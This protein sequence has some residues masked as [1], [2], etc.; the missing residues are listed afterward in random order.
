MPP[1]KNALQVLQDVFGYPAFRA[2]QQEVIDTVVSGGDALVLMPTGGGKS[3]CYQ[4]PAL[5]RRGCGVVVS[6]LIAL[7]Q[8]QVDALRQLGV[9]AAFLNSTLSLS[10]QRAVEN[11]LLQAASST[12]STSRPSGCSSR[13]RIAL[14]RQR[15]HR[16]VR[17]RRGALRLAVGPRFPRRVPAARAL[18][19][20]FPRRAAPRADRHRRRSARAPRS[21]RDW[22][23]ATRADFVAGFD[24]PNIRYRIV[25]EAEP[26]SSS[27][28]A[29][30]A[31]STRATPASSTACRARRPRTIAAL[32][33]RAA[34]STRCPTTPAWTPRR[35][36]RNQ[37]ALPARGRRDHRGDHRL[38]HGHRQARRALRRAPR[39][40]QDRRG[41]LPGNRPRRPRR[42]A[43]RR[44]AALRP[45][46]R[47]HAA[48]DAR[49][50]AGRRGAQ[51]RRAAAA[52]RDARLVRDHLVP[53]PGAAALFRRGL[54]RSA[55]ATATPA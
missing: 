11:A 17:D 28:C 48:P 3:L 15:R 42:P 40:A 27:C 36:R 13:R 24:R 32:A 5:L 2:P 55:A 29:S 10:A 46:G 9:R 31:T 8:D 52:E 19:E 16:A 51:A 34:A 7:M 50:L 53:A 39:P 1:M 37:D 22:T 33:L 4:I 21:S 54:A 6:P 49:E 45:A 44:L 47:D 23:S 14:L 25:P 41:L 12:C 30:C 38:R 26:A 20:R 35:A 43:R 18:H